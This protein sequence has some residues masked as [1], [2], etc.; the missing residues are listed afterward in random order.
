MGNYNSEYESYYNS[1]VNKKTSGNYYDSRNASHGSS[2]KGVGIGS[3]SNFFS[4]Q[5]IFRRVI[6][7]LIGGLLL[8]VLLIFC[9][10]NVLAQSKTVYNYSKQIVHQNFDI[11]EL[12]NNLNNIKNFKLDNFQAKASDFIESIKIN[13]VGG[14]SVTEKIKTNYIMPTQG[15]ITTTFSSQNANKTGLDIDAKENSDVACSFQGKVKD[16]GETAI[17]GKYIEVDH[18]DGIITKYSNLNEQLVKKGD[19]VKKGQVIGKSGKAGKST[20]PHVHYQIIYMGNEIDP[21]EYIT[22]SI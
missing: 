10:S 11:S 20:G 8:F 14:K 18:G 17:I 9:K 13:L 3:I 2:S 7:E 1:M 21:K 16:I 22:F 12:P 4:K 19:S 5:R 6:Q 15:K